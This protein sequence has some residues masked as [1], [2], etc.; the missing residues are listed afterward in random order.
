MNNNT[1]IK[2]L[3]KMK[4]P[5]SSLT[6]TV[7]TVF[8]ASLLASPFLLSDAHA[9][10]YFSAKVAGPVTNIYSVNDD[11]KLNKLTDNIRWRDLE[12]NVSS[13]GLV[14]YASNQEKSTAVNM[15]RKSENFNI[16]LLNPAD[17]KSIALTTSTDQ[18][19]TPKFSPDGSQLAFISGGAEGQTLK[20]MDLKSKK[21][22]ALSSGVEIYDFSWSPSAE[23]IVLAK[24]NG[25]QSTIDVVTLSTGASKEI[26]SVPMKKPAEKNGK[27][28][29]FGLVTSASWS[30]KEDNIAYILHPYKKNVS[31]QLHLYN[32]K[33]KKTVNISGNKVQVQAPIDWSDDGEQ[34][35][36]SALVDYKYY[37]NEQTHR[38]VYEG[39]M[40]V[41]LSDLSGNGK[42]ITSGDHLFKHPVFSP[43]EKQIGFLY[44]DELRN[45]TLALKTMKID[46]GDQKTLNSQVAQSGSLVWK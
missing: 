45:R 22:K 26:I 41:F 1:K 36:Y 2:K 46:G 14:A 23:R 8:Y 21:V 18:E 4:R 20:V 37:Y 16:Y 32:L 3:L 5:K 42:Q 15:Q 43:D 33:T 27:S 35:L 39:G 40:H 30:P 31:R 9:D 38:K 34:L 24:T 13:K 44:A 25:E 6:Q 7:K 19:R 12:H 29:F 28:D 11:G 10:L 17:G